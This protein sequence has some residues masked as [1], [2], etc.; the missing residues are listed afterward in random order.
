MVSILKALGFLLPFLTY[1]VASNWDSTTISKEDLVFLVHLL[2]SVAGF[3]LL[4]N[5]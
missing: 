3:Y 1:C 5:T 2:E 4:Q